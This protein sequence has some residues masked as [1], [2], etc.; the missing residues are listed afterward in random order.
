MP[1]ASPGYYYLDPMHPDFPECAWIMYPEGNN[2]TPVIVAA[3]DV[4]A[5]Q[6]MDRSRTQPTAG[7]GVHRPPQQGDA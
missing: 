4:T 7:T 5:E 3:G 2:P 1:T 6:L